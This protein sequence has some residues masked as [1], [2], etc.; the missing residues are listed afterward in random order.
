M[1]HF[2]MS[3]K[4][5]IS[6][7]VLLCFGLST[8]CPASSL[9]QSTLLPP[10][11]VFLPT[12]GTKVMPSQVSTPIML[13][14]VKVDPTNPMRF[15]FILNVT[16]ND[17]HL[18]D[19][20]Q[21]LIKYFLAC[22]SIPE[23]DL[24]VNLSPYEKD[25]MIPDALGK[26]EL[27][28]DLL[29]QDYVLKQLTASLLDPQTTTGKAFWAK[30]YTKAQAQAQFGTTNVPVNT[31]NKVWILADTARIFTKNNTA[32]VLSSN[33]KVML[34]S[35]Y[36]A[37]E[38]NKVQTPTGP[39]PAA[40]SQSSG[41]GKLAPPVERAP[42]SGPPVENRN[43]LTGELSKLIIK[44]IVI[45]E[46]T[47]EVNHGENFAPLRQMYNAFILA[48]WYKKNLKT[49]IINQYYSNQNKIHG[50]EY[51]N[52]INVES[53]YQ[54]YLQAFKKGVVNQ[55]QE[56]QD[57]ITHTVVPRKYFTGGTEF[58]DRAEVVADAALLSPQESNA[59]AQESNYVVQADMAMFGFGRNRLKEAF[60]KVASAKR[61]EIRKRHKAA[62]PQQQLINQASAEYTPWR[63]NSIPR[64]DLVIFKR[65]YL[66]LESWE[67]V[68]LYS[69]DDI[70]ARMKAGKVFKRIIKRLQDEI[71]EQ[72]FKMNRELFR[73]LSEKVY[74]EHLEL[75]QAAWKDGFINVFKMYYQEKNKFV[76]DVLLEI[77]EQ[78]LIYDKSPQYPR[79]R[80]EYQQ[81]LA[82]TKT[83]KKDH[84]AVMGITRTATPDEVKKAFRKLAVKYHPDK[85]PGDK[86]AEDNFRELVEA[87]E[88]L[89]DPEKRA[90]YDRDM[91][92]TMAYDVNQ[93]M[94]VDSWQAQERLEVAVRSLEHSKTI[95]NYSA[96]A[97]ASG[98][99]EREVAEFQD[100]PQLRLLK[101]KSRTLHNSIHKARTAALYFKLM[102]APL[103][104]Q[105]FDEIINAFKDVR[106]VMRRYWINNPTADPKE[107]KIIA[108][109]VD[110]IPGPWALWQ[111]R[112]LLANGE[113]GNDKF[114]LKQIVESL[115]QPAEN[116]ELIEEDTGIQFHGNTLSFMSVMFD[117]YTNARQAMQNAGK[118]KILVRKIEDGRAQIIVEDSGKGIQQQPIDLLAFDP[119]TGRL[120]I[121][122]LNETT[123][124]NA[125]EK[126]TG[127][128]TT[129]AWY[130]I[131]DMGGEIIARNKKD[132]EGN[133][134]GAEFIITLPIVN[135][136]MITSDLDEIRRISAVQLLE[137]QHGQSVTS[138]FDEI[139]L[140]L[141]APQFSAE[142]KRIDGLSRD[143]L[144][145]EYVQVQGD[146]DAMNRV[147]HPTLG[148]KELVQDLKNT[149]NLI[150]PQSE[151]FV[152]NYA[153]IY[154]ILKYLVIVSDKDY[155][156]V[157]NANE[158]TELQEYLKKDVFIIPG[159]FKFFAHRPFE[160]MLRFLQLCDFFVG[161]LTGE[162]NYGKP[163]AQSASELKA[164]LFNSVASQ[165]SIQNYVSIL[166]EL[167]EDPLSPWSKFLD[168]AQN[169]G[170][171][172]E[173][174]AKRRHYLAKLDI[175]KES[176]RPTKRR[177]KLVS[178]MTEIFKQDSVTNAQRTSEDST[179]EILVTD[180]I[181]R[182]YQYIGMPPAIVEEAIANLLKWIESDDPF[183][184]V[185]ASAVLLGHQ[186]K[187]EIAQLTRSKVVKVTQK[188][189]DD[190]KGPVVL[191]K[192][193]AHTAKMPHNEVETEDT[194]W[195]EI[196]KEKVLAWLDEMNVDEE[197]HRREWTV[198]DAMILRLTA[199]VV[200][201]DNSSA[202]KRI[203]RHKTINTIL[204]HI[205]DKYTLLAQ[206][207]RDELLNLL[208]V[209]ITIK[210]L[211]L[212]EED[213]LTAKI[214]VVLFPALQDVR[215]NDWKNFWTEAK[216]LSTC[217]PLFALALLD[218][219]NDLKNPTII[220]RLREF[221][222]EDLD[223]RFPTPPEAVLLLLSA[224]S[225]PDDFELRPKKD[226]KDLVE[227]IP[228]PVKP[229]SNAAM[230]SKD[231][232][233]AMKDVIE[234]IYKN[235]TE[236]SEGHEHISE[237]EKFW[238]LRVVDYM[239]KA[240]YL[241]PMRVVVGG[242][243]QAYPN[244]IQDAIQFIGETLN[245]NDI[246]YAQTAA[247]VIL[248]HPEIVT[249]LTT[250][251]GQQQIIRQR[252]KDLILKRL[253]DQTIDYDLPFFSE[254]AAKADDL[255]QYQNEQQKW[256]ETFEKQIRDVPL[257]DKYTDMLTNRSVYT[258]LSVDGRYKLLYFGLMSYKQF[259]ISDPSYM[260]Y[261]KG[262]LDYNLRLQ[263]NSDDG[264]KIWQAVDFETMT[265]VL[266]ALNHVDLF[267][268]SAM[269]VRK[270]RESKKTVLLV[271]DDLRVLRYL[272]RSFK[273][274]GYSVITAISGSEALEKIKS[275][276]GLNLIITDLHMDNGPGTYLVNQLKRM[277]N[278]VP[279]FVFAGGDTDYQREVFKDSK[280]VKGYFSK[281]RGFDGVVSKALEMLKNP[282][283]ST[284]TG[285]IDFNSNDLIV[286]ETGDNLK[287]SN[288][289][290]LIAQFQSP[291]FDGLYPVIVDI[292]PIHGAAQL[293]SLEF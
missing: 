48:N 178:I 32:Y 80:A 33:L 38:K 78:W 142:K 7:L 246:L 241:W 36:L 146:K 26:T 252:A 197:L 30:V 111:S 130:V 70:A 169:D 133:V 141:A 274:K 262:L 292:K 13:N 289:Q 236:V 189:G 198:A 88:I 11:Q 16:K 256:I 182:T 107:R 267:R 266:P 263:A 200:T 293:L 211:S 190:L 285:G 228:V 21:R 121:F 50:A 137:A 67:E 56:E 116:Y 229:Q 123:K 245:S 85:N 96:I 8:I 152:K 188:Q 68:I 10:S 148:H 230:T 64:D 72:R 248:L 237:A 44:E 187:E 17:A 249:V 185:A 183:L 69:A 193:I 166:E 27:G 251:I 167:Q 154:L 160:H 283:M 106:N 51:E 214:N 119:K 155:V 86:E 240:P 23:K 264:K 20:A 203:S 179:R 76:T 290:A 39:V 41:L 127:L 87:N 90:A 138:L 95:F 235:G 115:K 54:K 29:A 186:D 46:I 25:R 52:S 272:E 226:P 128:G 61:E 199:S 81:A 4:K 143:E 156:F 45:P 97:F 126:G 145:Q 195:N 233:D 103:D 149:V 18:R 276:G 216:H 247:A 273:D 151:D 71:L 234:E 173:L 222:D 92:M 28:R 254:A 175:L 112:R 191:T 19:D 243:T 140:N 227:K 269:A 162:V 215:T 24:W 14:G 288:D 77:I 287:F 270:T 268:D 217:Y 279:V 101:E 164:L 2:H 192:P 43:S 275:S 223:L 204:D 221:L 157:D 153:R 194:L 250:D 93:G 280:Q 206:D 102:K 98:Y 99:I 79:V 40:P 100:T 132:K 3:L 6:L 122:N 104:P 124:N 35:D 131:K 89:S 177:L 180:R 94:D 113:R 238:A 176:I 213:P 265:Q 37:Q 232:K 255:N 120:V 163:Y 108:G 207:N 109:I 84:Y 224:L 114:S 75:W 66:G 231:R 225:Y 22:L 129:E 15:D 82:L 196:A 259:A 165:Q 74:K 205:L 281:N 91:A 147:W 117:L 144:L 181:L 5:S 291:D 63:D 135:P 218:N 55:I 260:N 158:R 136:A 57:P 34:D 60:E 208:A 171:P 201:S 220:A 284:A 65:Y 202:G 105:I 9:A 1:L 49:S 53:I 73:S 62:E 210:S 257:Y 172:P 174:Q 219:K 139:F 31:F 58:Q 242:S 170:I 150:T 59:I 161:K 42:A 239:L 168:A 159:N 261:I 277:G 110:M 184:S 12:P 286:K 83:T 258:S 209:A 271:D 134:I 282:A 125:E 253:H 212:P 244:I 278:K 47:H 118:V